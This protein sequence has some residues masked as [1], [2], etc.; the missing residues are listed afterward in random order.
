MRAPP[1]YHFITPL[2]DVGIMQT[3]MVLHMCV[4]AKHGDNNE[5]ARLKVISDLPIHRSRLCYLRATVSLIC[6]TRR[7]RTM[8]AVVITKLRVPRIKKRLQVSLLRIE[9]N[10][11]NEVL[12]RRQLKLL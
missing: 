5:I 3:E 9:K 12:K 10:F 2:R 1:V 11:L 8:L 7:T 6:V 4:P